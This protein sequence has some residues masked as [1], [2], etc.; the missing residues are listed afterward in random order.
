LLRIVPCLVVAACAHTVPD[1]RNN[2]WQFWLDDPGGRDPAVL[3]RAGKDI[4]DLG[5][6]EAD[7][8]P[9]PAVV[10]RVG[11][12]FLSSADAFIATVCGHVRCVAPAEGARARIAAVLSVR[13]RATP[14]RP[15]E[16]DAPFGMSGTQRFDSDVGPIFVA[17]FS[18][19]C[20]V[21][22]ELGAGAL[23]YELGA[24]FENLKTGDNLL[25][26]ESIGFYDAPPTPGWGPRWASADNNGTE[27]M[28]SHTEPNKLFVSRQLLGQ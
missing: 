23:I 11:R 15:E 4:Y 13:W 28:M 24:A 26:D 5:D 6:I 9:D 22:I 3:R 18:S 25:C 12:A 16:R 27:K 21:G 8:K 19:R 17:C 2:D 10:E 7:E 1:F 14:Y 20:A